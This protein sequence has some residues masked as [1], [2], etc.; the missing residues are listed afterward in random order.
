MLRITA[1]QTQVAVNILTTAFLDDPM[2]S[3]ILPERASRLQALPPI[4]ELFIKDGIQRGE[5]LLALQGVIVWYP[6]NVVV[7]DD[8]FGAVHDEI[9]SIAIH[10]G[11]IET[12]ERLEKISQQSQRQ[13]PTISHHE[14]FWIAVLPEYQGRGVGSQLLKTV[15]DQADTENITCYV[16]SSNLCNS[17]FYQRHGF[18]QSWPMPIDSN[19]SLLGMWRNPVSKIT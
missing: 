17:T 3:F 16:V 10:F 8:A 19:F 1:Q 4:F 15:L 6:S 9:T 11:G 2:W 5:V 14:I 12:T 7:F 18:N 13:T